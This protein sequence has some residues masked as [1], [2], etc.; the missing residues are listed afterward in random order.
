MKIGLSIYSLYKEIRA[1][2]LTVEEAI[3]LIADFGAEHVELVDFVVE[4]AEHPD[5]IDAVV[6]RCRAR[7]LP[8]SAYCV[9]ADVLDMDAD[10]ADKETRRII[11]HIDIARKL[12]AKILRSDL[13]KWG[14]PPEANAIEIFEKSMPRLTETCCKLA[15]YAKPHGI[16]V[17]VENHGTFING[18]DRVR[19]LITA[20]GRENFRCTLDVGNSLCVDEDPA[21]CAKILLP[22]AAT[23]HFKDFVYRTDGVACGADGP[24]AF[25]LANWMTTNYGN[26]LK[27]TIVGDGDVDVVGLM[28]LIRKAGFDGDVAIEF[29]GMENCREGSR[30]S[31]ENV[32]R[33]RE[34][35]IT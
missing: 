10:A 13:S 30:I 27:G 14:R 9:C 16:T 28:R 7:N 26:F 15:D 33:Y 5:R 11:D 23:V 17:T 19:R 12:G 29:E 6:A 3:D 1:G 21:V 8:I 25:R 22:F 18:G 34:L 20:V 24:P 31:L 2:I 4:F 32:K 35:A